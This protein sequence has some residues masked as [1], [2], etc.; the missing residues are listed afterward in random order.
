[1][2]PSNSVGSILLLLVLRYSLVRLLPLPLTALPALAETPSAA[3]ADASPLLA[4]DS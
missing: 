2:N 4:E 3:A 1:M